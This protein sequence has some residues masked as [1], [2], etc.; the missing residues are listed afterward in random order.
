[1]G[2]GGGG[3]CFDEFIDGLDPVVLKSETIL[4]INEPLATNTMNT[5]HF[6]LPPE[7]FLCTHSEANA[8]G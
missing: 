6:H 3:G 2:R 7:S 1:M 4:L 8:S 5:N